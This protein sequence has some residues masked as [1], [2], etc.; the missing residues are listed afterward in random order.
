MRGKRLWQI[1]LHK[2]NDATDTIKRHL[3][4]FSIIN[5]VVLSNGSI[6]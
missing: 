6:Y 3:G 5:V 4:H 1:G 2:I